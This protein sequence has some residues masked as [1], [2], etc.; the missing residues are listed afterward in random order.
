MANVHLKQSPPELTQVFQVS[1]S[2][3]RI[4]FLLV[5]MLLIQEALEF[6][7]LVYHHRPKTLREEYEGCLFW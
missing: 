1:R 2:E 7:V 5:V 4:R 6:H 3:A